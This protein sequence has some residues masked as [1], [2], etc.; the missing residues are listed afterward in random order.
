MEC[1]VRS[2]SATLIFCLQKIWVH[3][4]AC[5]GCS[6]DNCIPSPELGGWILPKQNMEALNPLLERKTATGVLQ[7]HNVITLLS[8]QIC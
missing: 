5:K 8:L 2:C 7:E 6:T 1:S 3:G 4:L